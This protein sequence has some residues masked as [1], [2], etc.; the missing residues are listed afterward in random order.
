MQHLGDDQDAVV[1]EG[2]HHQPAHQ[3]PG[4]AHEQEATRPQRLHDGIGKGKEQHLRHDSC[5]PEHAD[6]Q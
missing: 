4:N 1:A 6:P 2:S 5:D 3:A